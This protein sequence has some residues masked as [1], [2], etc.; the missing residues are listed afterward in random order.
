MQRWVDKEKRLVTYLEE[1]P[2][3]YYIV[4][5]DVGQLVD[6]LADALRQWFEIASRANRG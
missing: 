5:N 1:Y 4:V 2:F 6:V 3:T